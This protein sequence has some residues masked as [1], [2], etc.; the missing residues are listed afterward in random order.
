MQFNIQNF[1]STFIGSQFPS[2]YEEQG[3]NFI[4]FMKAYY[5]W[6]ESNIP[7]V[8]TSN[9]LILTVDGANT[10]PPL[11]AARQLFNYRDIDNTLEE[12]LDHFQ[13]K[14][15]YGIP[16]DIIIN[17]RFLL[18]HIFDIYRS[19]GSIRCYKL[20]F[21]LIY[22]EDIDVYLP[23]YDMLK[24][25]D[26][27]WNT[28]MYVEV[29]NINN[30]S[31]FIGKTII[32]LSSGV[33]AIIEFYISESINGNIVNVLYISNI[34]PTVKSFIVN[35]NI[36]IVDAQGNV[37]ETG[38]VI[39][40]SI[41]EF[42]ITEG[43]YNF[44]IGDVLAV[45]S[46]LSNNNYVL[47]N[48][49]DCLIKVSNT[50]QMYGSVFFNVIDPGNGISANA[51]IFNYY[52]NSTGI[53]ANFL[54]GSLENVEE[55]SYNTD[56]IGNYSNVTLNA[57]SFGFP[58]NTSANSSSNLG[59]AL[60]FTNNIFGSIGVIASQNSGYN[61]TSTPTTFIRSTIDSLLLSGTIS[62]STTSNAITGTSTLF[63]NFF[64]TNTVIV[65]GNSTYSEAHVVS[66]VSNNTYLTLYDKPLTNSTGSSTYKVSVDVFP[67]NFL[68]NNP[69]MYT[70]DN[71][72][73]GLNALI[74]G[75]LSTGNGVVT[76]T[77][78]IDSGRNYIDGEQVT[79]YL[80]NSVTTPTIVY[81]GN[82][83]ANGELLVFVDPL[84]NRRATG[85]VNTNSNGAITSVTMN[86]YGSGYIAVP[87]V[88]IQTANGK[89]AYLTTSL[90]QFSQNNFIKGNLI[91]GGIGVKQGN[92]T[93]TNGFLN[94][95]KYIQDSYFYQVFSYQIKVADMLQNYK[96]ILYDTFHPAGT[97]MFGEFKSA[98]SLNA[99]IEIITNLN[100]SQNG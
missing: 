45:P 63:T 84:V 5:E 86:T 68:P 87:N 100:V 71:K 43:S 37:I 65:L 61:Y 28:P 51:S 1:V 46:Y 31:N 23:S 56:I 15:L 58:G 74:Q 36:S 20:L 39:L 72:I 50:G 16:F 59:I 55:V 76:S 25:S 47:G 83:Y 70:S 33:T 54:L 73:S 79:A 41:T 97:E 4:L 30:I 24:P 69:I 48:G 89:N 96:S 99:S 98:E 75:S 66:L 6:M 26:G 90:V 88:V 3:P 2:F 9:N 7:L 35:E 91:K 8:D 62:Y 21:K 38:P 95:D 67:S 17:K 42:Q 93:T 57:A 94:S 78:I 19:K 40:G 18:K 13:K 11:Y 77:K 27:T 49:I 44:G 82:N 80:Y 60:S 34:S 32:G 53:G 92:W 52:N 22:N 12:F 64:G 10:T 14:Y 81:G 85:F 29:S